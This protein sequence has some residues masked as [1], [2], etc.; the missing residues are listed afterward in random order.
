MAKRQLSNINENVANKIIDGISEM[1]FDVDAG[2]K[3]LNNEKGN[4]EKEIKELREKLH[5]IE[6]KIQP[7]LN[8][9]NEARIKKVEEDISVIKERLAIAETSKNYNEKSSDKMETKLEKNTDKIWDMSLKIA[10]AGG[11]AAGVWALIQQ[12][13]K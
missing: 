5:Q 11:I 8:M 10:A 2:V 3:R 13:A 6:I 9:D 12:F 1:L 4:C 7:L